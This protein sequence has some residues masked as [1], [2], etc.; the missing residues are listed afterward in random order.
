MG[1]LYMFNTLP[2]NITVELNGGPEVYQIYKNSGEDGS[3]P[4]YLP[5]VNKQI[6]IGDPMSSKQ[7]YSGQNSF[8]VLVYGNTTQIN[9]NLTIPESID[10]NADLILFIYYNEIVLCN[11]SGFVIAS[12]YSSG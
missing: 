11:T 6:G 10:V 3:P 9:F 7:V 1:L 12:A 2:D 8:N 4:H 5:L